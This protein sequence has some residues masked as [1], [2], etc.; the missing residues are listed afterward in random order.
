MQIANDVSP[1]SQLN[2]LFVLGFHSH[3]YPS[4][5]GG[6]DRRHRNRDRTL[7]R[8]TNGDTKV[9]TGKMHS[10]ETSYRVQCRSRP[11]EEC[12]LADMDRCDG[13]L[14]SRSAQLDI[15]R[16]SEEAPTG[17]SECRNANRMYSRAYTGKRGVA[18]RKQGACLVQK[19]RAHAPGLHI[20][21]GLRVIGFDA[22]TRA[23]EFLHGIR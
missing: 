16:H 21:S 3:A 20:L 4:S 9:A 17:D 8:P 13:C 6:P 10:P 1:P 18:H 5:R 15:V 14:Q 7:K 23:H 12:E 22:R 2:S 11:Q 19:Q